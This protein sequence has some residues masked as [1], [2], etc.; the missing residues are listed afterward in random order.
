MIFVANQSRR[1]GKGSREFVSPSLELVGE[2]L[3]EA[4]KAFQEMVAGVKLGLI[5]RQAL[6]ES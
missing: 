3:S 4:C 2:A 1:N 6:S 5:M